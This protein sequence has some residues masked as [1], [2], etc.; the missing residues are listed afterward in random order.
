MRRGGLAKQVG[1]TILSDV[2]FVFLSL[3]EKGTG[4]QS[5]LS[6]T[7]SRIMARAKFAGEV[8]REAAK[9]RLRVLA[10]R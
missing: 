9:E 1:T 7:F 10:T 8:L 6:P 2:T 3:A 5:G 4:R